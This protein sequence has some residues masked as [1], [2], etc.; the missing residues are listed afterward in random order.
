MSILVALVTF[1]SPHGGTVRQDPDL[2]GLLFILIIR[3]TGGRQERAA[4]ACRHLTTGKGRGLK[5]EHVPKQLAFPAESHRA[6]RKCEP[7]FETSLPSLVRYLLP[8]RPWLSP[9]GQP[10]YYIRG[11]GRGRGRGGRARGD[12]QGRTLPPPDN[13]GDCTGMRAPAFAYCL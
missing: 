1:S 6:S 7:R 9:G 12:N 3:A 2:N 10:W 5:T 4:R 8:T 13:R 11:H